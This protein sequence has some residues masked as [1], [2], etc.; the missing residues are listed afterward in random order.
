MEKGQDIREQILAR[1]EELKKEFETGQAELDKVEKQRT[2]L[3]E[4]MLQI[5]GAIQVLRELLA[6]GRS[7][8][9][10]NGSDPTEVRSEPADPRQVSGRNR[11][12]DQ[13]NQ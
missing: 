8:E 10:Q 12:T 1:L 13:A 7:V 2:Y 3:R 5:S 9:Q 6:E 11:N 4:N